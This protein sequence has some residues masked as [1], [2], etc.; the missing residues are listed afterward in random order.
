MPTKIYRG[1]IPNTTAITHEAQLD[2][3]LTSVKPGALVKLNAAG[4]WVNAVAADVQG[5]TVYVVGEELY[6]GVDD[7]LT[8]ADGN[9]VRAYEL[10]GGHLYAV[11]AA[12]GITLT[13]DALLGFAAGKA[14][15]ADADG[16]GRLFVDVPSS[17]QSALAGKVTTADQL[18]PVKFI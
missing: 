9:S 1:G 2:A 13:N 8:A 12:A 4:K 15:A 14:G 7:T 10:Q 16:V 11:R 5:V 6:G 3:T 18:I 17:A